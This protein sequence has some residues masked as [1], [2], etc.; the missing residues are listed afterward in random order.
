MEEN[1]KMNNSIKNENIISDNT[2]NLKNDIKSLYIKQKIFS[3]M[4]SNKK[5]KYIR[6]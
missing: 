1:K 4:S 6:L 3:L 5:I 2:T